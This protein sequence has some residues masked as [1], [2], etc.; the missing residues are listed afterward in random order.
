MFYG[1]FFYHVTTCDSLDVVNNCEVK[2]RSPKARKH[3]IVLVLSFS[4]SL[5]KLCLVII[6]I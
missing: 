6:T 1:L 5:I 2:H 4:F 3:P